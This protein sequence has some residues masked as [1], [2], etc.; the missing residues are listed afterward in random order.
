MDKRTFMGYRRENNAVGVRNHVAILPLDDIS[1]AAAEGVSRIIQGTL[2]LPHPYGRLQFGAD[3]ALFF[4]TIIGTGCN[5][6]VAAIV[7][8][9]I[10]P[11]W[12]EK[13]VRG[14]AETGKPVEGFSI[15]RQGD[16]RTIEK[17]ART[18]K[19][20]VH[21]ASEMK[22]ES[23]DLEELVMSVKCGES[24]TTSGLASNPTVGKVVERLV[25]AGA[26]VMF[27]ETSELTGGEHLVADRMKTPRPSSPRRPCPHRQYSFQNCKH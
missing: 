1:N 10:E 4:R 24:D 15:E 25:E 5:P 17:A 3:L 26:T 12:T 13:V 19:G 16:L 7:V 18:A 9:G 21:K 6:N 14:I 27:G 2:P 11:N 20:F 22:R 23:V 8:I